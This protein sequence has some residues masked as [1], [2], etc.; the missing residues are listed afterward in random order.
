MR[1]TLCSSPITTPRLKHQYAYRFNHILSLF[2]DLKFFQAIWGIYVA[3]SS[4]AKAAMCKR[5]AP[6]TDETA[7]TQDG[8]LTVSCSAIDSSP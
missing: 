4:L 1:T 2:T 3:C 6:V 5:G 7:L 8:H